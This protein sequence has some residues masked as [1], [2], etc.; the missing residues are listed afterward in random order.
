[1]VDFHKLVN[2]RKAADTSNL[3]AL[4]ESLDRKASHIE[5]R[6][7]QRDALKM[8]S[9]RRDTR[10]LVLKMSTGSGKTT[11]GLIYLFSFMDEFKQP[12]VYLCP[13]NQLVDQV[14]SEAQN[15]GINAAPYLAGQVH[16]DVDGIRGKALIVCTYDKLF[17]AKTT[18]DR[19]DVRIRPIAIV[20]DD[21]HAGVEEVRDA[22][23][24]RIP[25][26][27]LF[28]QLASILNA[29]CSHF[30]PGA[31]RE[32]RDRDHRRSLE[33]PYWIWKPLVSPIEEAISVAARQ[34]DGLQFVWPYIQGIL[35]WCR[36]VVSGSGLEIVPEIL[37]VQKSQA[38]HAALHRLFMSAT[39]ADDSVLVRE[40]GCDNESAKTPIVTSNDRGLGERM[41]LAPSLVSEKLDRQWMMDICSRLA[42]KLRFR[43][44]VLSPSETRAKDWESV[45]ATVVMGSDVSHAIG[46]LRDKASTLRFVVF[47]QRYD[48]ID[49]PD[50]ACRVL[51]LDG[52]PIGEGI[53]D[54]YDTALSD[55]SGG[56]RSRL[57]YR[58]EQGMGRAVRSHADYAV[59]VLIGAELAHFVAKHEVLAAMNPDTATQLRLAI[60]LAKLA[61]EENAED[62]GRAVVGMIRQCLTRDEGWKR[63]YNETIRGLESPL[64]G[65]TSSDRVDLS[66]AERRAF[67]AALANDPFQAA[68]VLREALNEFCAPDDRITG[69][70]L[71]RVANYLYDADPGES[72][73]VQRAAYEKN[74]SMFCPPGVVK[75]PSCGQN[76]DTQAVMLA[77]FREFQNPNGA[78]AAIEDLRGRLSYDLSP[79]VFEQSLMDLAP[80]LGAAGSRPE[81]ECGEGPDDLWLWADSSFVVEAKNENE[82]TL[83]KKD[84][85]QMTLSLAW[86]ERNYPTRGSPI[87]LVVA[88]T[89]R[90]DHH[91]TYPDGTRVLLPEG[92]QDLLN[93]LHQ[94]YKTLISEPLRL[95]TP[96]QIAELQRN[97]DLTPNQIASGLAVPVQELTD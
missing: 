19:T 30:N 78:I 2:R 53:V 83:H 85:A 20:L 67:T 27:E 61:T 73:G 96:K 52:L 91:A 65:V 88:K 54:R 13:T 47:V 24:L 95:N 28:T 74:G 86:F 7:A 18:F 12:A 64:T 76:L 68:S 57:V 51:V 14:C 82:S 33:V 5:L 23:T 80:L 70:Y 75:R 45:G 26:G 10:D 25:D 59:V 22:F 63:Y 3:P 66:D 46:Q 60:D 81:K 41:V 84:A 38:Y 40:L 29:G 31:W 48:G 49:L 89:A 37:P 56:T 79:A 21:A 55:V 62:P 69:W 34:D 4:F 50:D 35:R 93:R 43:V 42:E 44:V 39:L 11:A 58:I 9:D 6:L 77:W 71:Q 17:N 97:L 87:P 16:P 8:L 72:L 15:L 1:M 94:F 92:M 90:S 32:I 36:C